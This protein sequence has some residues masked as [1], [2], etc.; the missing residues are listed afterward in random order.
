MIEF[1]VFG[2]GSWATALVK[3]LTDNKI[4]VNWYLRRAKQANAIQET[5]SNPD[6]LNFVHLDTQYIR[7]SSDKQTVARKSPVILFAVPSGQLANLLEDF[8]AAW[9]NGKI[10]LNSIKGTVGDQHEIPSAF[11]STQLGI[12]EKLQGILAGPCH[13]EEI[14]H[15]KKTYLTVAA[16]DVEVQ[17]LLRGCFVSDYIEV[18][19]A[20][21]IAG[22]E[23]AAIYKNVVGLVCGMAK[24]LHYGDNFLAV[25]VANALQEL[26]DVLQQMGRS[27]ELLNS[28]YAGDLLVTAYSAHSRNRSF[29]E[30]IGRGYSVDK[31]KGA[32][33]MVA[34]GYRATRGLYQLTKE[35]PCQL[36]ILQ[37]A[38]R[39][40]FKYMP[41]LTEFK[42]L[43]Q[44]LK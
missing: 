27:S 32:M 29:G 31:A 25:L 5:G 24:G 3:I 15:R 34:E 40:L 9:I 16:P 1:G 36:P 20:N 41:V 26:K 18:R 2:G 8:D 28:S 43:E 7:C 19:L 35:L 6:Y 42:L 38:Y 13:A 22:I 23:Y 10:V 14:G 37:T 21:D 44:K 11:I 17:Q 4:T 39:V 30:M 33:Q 12:P